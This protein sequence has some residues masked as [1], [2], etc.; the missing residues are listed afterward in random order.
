MKRFN[1]ILSS[2]DGDRQRPRALTRAFVLAEGNDVTLT[3]VDVVRPLSTP[4]EVTS[5]LPADLAVMGAAGRGGL[6]GFFISNTAEEVLQT[7]ATS[8]VAVKPE[9]FE[10]PESGTRA[11]CPVN[12]IWQ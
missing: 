12:G 4:T 1:G 5:H 8:A 6:P 11:V 3:L 10:S 9:N 2:D 7:T